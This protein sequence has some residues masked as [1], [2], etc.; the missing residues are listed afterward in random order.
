MTH[1]GLEPPIR[2]PED[3]YKVTGF[4]A[5]TLVTGKHTTPGNMASL[6]LRVSNLYEINS[7]QKDLFWHGSCPL[8]HPPPQGEICPHPLGLHNSL[9]S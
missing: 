3:P 1:W 8:E 2:I 7:F 5:A 9:K 6:L 4:T